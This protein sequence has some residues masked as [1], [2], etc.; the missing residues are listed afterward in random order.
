MI[1]LIFATGPN[2]EFGFGSR[3]PWDLP[4][5]LKQFKE[6]TEGCVLLMSGAT[7]ASLPGK[8]PGRPHYVIG[9]RESIAK[10]GSKPDFLIDRNSSYMALCERIEEETGKDVVVIGGR[11]LLERASAFCDQARISIVQGNEI[12]Q[13]DLFIES[14]YIIDRLDSRLGLSHRTQE[15]GYILAEWK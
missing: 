12:A 3:L 14:E 10:N 7:F 9:P 5:D 15:D 6:Y 8:L 11:D 4:E 2:G 13:A 1:K